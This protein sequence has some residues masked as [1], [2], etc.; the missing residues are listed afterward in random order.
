[1]S[2]TFPNEERERG[3]TSHLIDYQAEKS[4]PINPGQVLTVAT[5]NTVITLAYEE[6]KLKCIM[7]DPHQQSARMGRNIGRGA[8]PKNRDET[9]P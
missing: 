6:V 9:P 8:R 4:T 3:P 1:M 2:P 7:E 5:H